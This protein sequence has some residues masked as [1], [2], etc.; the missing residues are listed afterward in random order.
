MALSDEEIRHRFGYHA[1]TSETVPRHEKLREGYIAFLKF[2][3][4]ELPDGRAKSTAFAKLQEASMWSHFGI[5]ELAPV[6]SPEYQ[7]KTPGRGRNYTIPKPGQESPR[8]ARKD[9]RQ[10]GRR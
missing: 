4:M 7:I 2:L 9:A 1:G 6:S 10:N 8:T 3:N 5:A